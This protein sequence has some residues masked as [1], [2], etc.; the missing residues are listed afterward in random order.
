ML[1]F[2]LNKY[3]KQLMPCKPSKARKL[4]RQGKAKI[5]KYEPFT[6]QLLYGS[7][8]YKQKCIIGIDAGSKNIGIAVTTEDG[9]TIYKAQLELRQDIKEN[10]ETRRRLR[11]ARRNRKT[12]YRKPR[13]LNRRR[14][15][16]W[17]SPSIK[18]RIDVHYNIIKRLSQIIPISKIRVEVG[19]FDTQALQNPDIRGIEYQNGEMKGFDS[20][21]EYVKIRDNFKC[22]Y[23]ELRPDIPCS[24]KLTIDHII[25]RSKGGTDNPSNLVCCCE[26]H[27]RQKGNLSYKKFTGK[28]P[29]AIRKFQAAVFMN[30]LKD[31]L[32]PKLE[33]ITST[34]YTFGLYTRIQ[35]KEWNLEKLHINDAI[36]I[37]GI[38][39]RW[40]VSTYYYIKQVRKKKRSLH[41][42]IPRKGRKEPNRKA[43]RN[44][45]NTKEIVVNGKKWCLWDKV[46]IPA[47]DK[48][49]YISG[50]SKKWVYVQDIEGNY[51][52]I[53]E[54]YKQIN[55]KELQLICRNNNF[56][57]QQFICTL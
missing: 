48:T 8:G 45:K 18:A 47:I 26:E 32:V 13:F 39:P 9:R 17:L 35:R 12:R 54:K 3:G 25:P 15:E 43:K 53:S 28:N 7:S 21:K 1:V 44:G 42:E 57:N 4:L 38:K 23:A 30:V 14:P 50:F 51:L 49:G 40:Q 2:V 52:Q 34:E 31:Y 5:V 56:V 10:I 27:N 19:Q 29:P 36:V 11:R 33:K 55:P 16:G 6:I 37:A 41:E 22:H 20:I 24:G 46:Y